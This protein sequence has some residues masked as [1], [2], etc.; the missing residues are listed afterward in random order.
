MSVS[1]QLY[2]LLPFLVCA[3]HPSGHPCDSLLA[4]ASLSSTASHLQKSGRDQSSKNGNPEVVGDILFHVITAWRAAALIVSGSDSV[5][6]AS[7][8]QSG[9]G[10]DPS[11]HTAYIP[12]GSGSGSKTARDVHTDLGAAQVSIPELLFSLYENRQW[13]ARFL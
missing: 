11:K 9:G 1:R 2:G 10:I 12:G 8:Q 5:L 3:R 4:A 7:N 6:P 13:G